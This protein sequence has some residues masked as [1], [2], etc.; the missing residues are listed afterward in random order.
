M[1]L[2]LDSSTAVEERVG[3]RFGL[4]QMNTAIE[5][6]KTFVRVKYKVNFL[7]GHRAF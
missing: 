6:M 2:G 7:V 4:M 3:A 5:N 1:G